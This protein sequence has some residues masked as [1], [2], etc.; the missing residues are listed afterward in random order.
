MILLLGELAKTSRRIVEASDETMLRIQLISKCRSLYIQA[1]TAFQQVP[2]TDPL[3]Y[4]Q[5]AGI[6][7]RPYIPWD[8][9]AW[10]PDAPNIGYCT[11]DD[12]LFPTWH[13][14][15]LALFEQVLAGHVQTIA[16]TY[17]SD[18][19]TAAANNFRI[20]YWDWAAI[21]ALPPIVSADTVEIETPTGTGT[22]A[23]PL[24]LYKFQQ[25]P[26]N[27][28]WFPNGTDV[29]EADQDLSQDP[30]T[31]RF[32]DEPIQGT[33]Q[34]P[35]VNEDLGAEGL[36]SMVYSVFT[37]STSYYNMATQ[38]SPGPSFENPH[39]AVH[40]AIGGQYGHM[41]Q[42]SYSAFDPMFWLH[43]A[44]VDRLFAMW[45]AIYPDVYLLPVVD[46]VGTFT[47]AA[48]T[49]DTS[50]SPLT[51]F[52]AADGET[53]WTSDSVRKTSTFGYSYPSVPDVTITDKNSLSANVTAT[54]NALY[55]P[56]GVSAGSK[57]K[58]QQQQQREW[59]VAV[60]ALSTALDKR[61]TVKVLVGGNP[62]S[63]VLHVLQPPVADGGVKPSLTFHNEFSLKQA[64]KDVDHSDQDAM[65]AFLKENLSWVVE[66]H[67]GTVVPNEQ[68]S[69]LVVTV[70]DEI[71][72][73]PGDE[74]Q[75][76]VYG[77]KTLHPEV[78]SGK[79]GGAT[80]S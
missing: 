24:L 15:Y 17:K 1:M 52:Y 30:F 4:F 65:V 55:N 77:A 80:S 50:S 35:I 79:A 60:Q 73:V 48:G 44:N 25:F 29:G 43:H 72:T 49:I 13:R 54:V 12:V 78:T 16:A 71:V 9:V 26:L 28:T 53:P 27:P 46:Q 39:G 57:I 19:Y 36:M 47:I 75:F 8:G 5:I 68:I 59:S 3:S 18:L 7:G 74:T 45:Q 64:V 10:N 22:V 34:P 40:V 76:P 70:Q 62:L 42:L 41:S 21:P 14:P 61:Y 69:G 63:T 58:R 31:L 37:K 23:N 32:P 38:I 2:E 56:E 20:P 6:H 66:K 33:S 67:D 51:P 11:H